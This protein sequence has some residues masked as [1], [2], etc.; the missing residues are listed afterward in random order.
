MPFCSVSGAWRSGWISVGLGAPSSIPGCL[1]AGCLSSIPGCLG[2]GCPSS[3]PGCLGAGC[4]SSIPGCLGPLSF[5]FSS[6][7]FPGGLVGFPFSWSAWHKRWQHMHI[8]FS[9]L[10]TVSE[11]C[12]LFSCQFLGQGIGSYVS[13][14]NQVWQRTQQ[15]CLTEGPLPISPIP[16]DTQ[17]VL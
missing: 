17:C 2:A 10:H 1:S 14:L 8:R 11:Q 13:S 15:N 3:I 12:W 6:S 9:C 7:A 16:R 4:P 5:T